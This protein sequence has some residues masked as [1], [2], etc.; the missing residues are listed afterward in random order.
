MSVTDRRVEHRRRTY[1]GAQVIF[2]RRLN[3]YDCLVRDMSEG[4]AKLVFAA[5]AMLPASFEI[6]VNTSGDS[7]QAEVKWRSKLAAGVS[8][9]EGRGAPF[10]SLQT[11]RKIRR[12]EEE[13][14]ALRTRVAE[15]SEP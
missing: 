10:V 6:V 13:R 1:L 9:V 12:L 11:A 4:G 7:K 2:N 15:L 8:F 5:P 14:A 3:V